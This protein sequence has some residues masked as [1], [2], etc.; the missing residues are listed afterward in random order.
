M[1]YINPSHVMYHG[2][3]A[4]GSNTFKT[5]EYLAMTFQ[6]EFSFIMAAFTHTSKTIGTIFIKTIL[7][8]PK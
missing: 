7:V 6:R 2:Q 3:S 5:Y 8:E 1:S 4:N